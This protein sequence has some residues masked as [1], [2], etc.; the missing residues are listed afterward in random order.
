M[1]VGFQIISFSSLFTAWRIRCLF[2]PNKQKLIP[3]YYP[4]FPFYMRRLRK[5]EGRH[6]TAIARMWAG[7]EARPAALWSLCRAFLPWPQRVPAT[8]AGWALPGSETSPVMPTPDAGLGTDLTAHPQPCCGLW[9]S[10]PRKPFLVG[11]LRCRCLCCLGSHVL[12]TRCFQRPVCSQHHRC[13]VSMTRLH[14]CSKPGPLCGGH[15]INPSSSH[16]PPRVLSGP[17]VLKLNSQWIKLTMPPTSASES[18]IITP[19]KDSDP[20]SKTLSLVIQKITSLFP[21]PP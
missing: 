6:G 8:G 11:S 19:P 17:L 13:L 15:V 14:L 7:A 5:R 21:F 3:C 1:Y 20:T 4:V 16:P 18:S 12:G 9:S 2:D 10:G